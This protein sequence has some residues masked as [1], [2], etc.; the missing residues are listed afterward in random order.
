MEQ[1]LK[2]VNMKYKNTFY[3]DIPLLCVISKP[4]CEH[5]SDYDFI[6]ILHIPMSSYTFECVFSSCQFHGTLNYLGYNVDLF[7]IYCQVLLSLL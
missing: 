3:L 6:Y 2:T 7:F 4:N 1:L 5:L